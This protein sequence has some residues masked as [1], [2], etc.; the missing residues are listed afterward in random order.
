MNHLEKKKQKPLWVKVIRSTVFL[1]F[2]ILYASLAAFSQ[3][4]TVKGTISVLKTGEI[5][6]GVTI[7]QK[8]TTNGTISD[9]DG[10]F[11][12]TVNSPDAVLV[13]SFVG[14][15][16]QEIPVKGNARIDVKLEE[17][18][19]E[20]D[21]VVAFGDVTTKKKD[22]T[23]SIG[24]VDGEMLISRGVSGVLGSMQGSVAGVNI[25]QSSSRPGADY[26]IQVRG[27]NSFSTS[28]PPLY[29]VDGIVTG[30]INFL[31]PQDIVKIDIL[32]DA[33]STA[34]YGSRGSNGVVLVT[35]KN[36]QSTGLK[37]KTVVSYNG[38]HGV[39]T[40]ARLPQQY[41]SRD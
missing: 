29:V 8:G 35:T 27:L 25:T 28:S 15:S 16:S 21:E 17:S 26:S 40:P 3:E 39:K 24:S 23:G 4:K 10:Q 14:Y 22:L 32:K 1:C 18:F 7:V 37:E 11:S 41:T 2:F 9:I 38:S 12:I 31:N 5:L 20:C 13:V 30:D 34:I 6:P 19:T 33:S 36:G